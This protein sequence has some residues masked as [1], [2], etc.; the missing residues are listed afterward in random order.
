MESCLIDNKVCSNKN[1][2][3]SICRLDDCK[4]AMR[5]I[6]S[7]EERFKR[8]QEEQLR[9]QLPASCRK[10][11]FLQ[12]LNLREKRVYCPYMINRCILM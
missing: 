5:M 7:Q 4:E 1:K 8:K 9:K 2:R 3:C 12:I 6:E 11:S 10:C